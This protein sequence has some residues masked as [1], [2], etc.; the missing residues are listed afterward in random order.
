MA[1]LKQKIIDEFYAKNL[2]ER[3]INRAKILEMLGLKERRLY[4]MVKNGVKRKKELE[5]YKEYLEF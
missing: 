3:R 4:D 2:Q 1:K 5:K